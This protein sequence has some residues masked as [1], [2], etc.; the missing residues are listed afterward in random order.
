M[1]YE[2][3]GFFGQVVFTCG[4]IMEEQK[5]NIYYGAADDSVCMAE[6]SLEDLYLH[7]GV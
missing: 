4:A 3:N 5:V 6:I 7:L 1:E 2:V